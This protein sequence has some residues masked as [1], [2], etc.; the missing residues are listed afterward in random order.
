MPYTLLT[1]PDWVKKMP[2]GAQEIWVNAFNAAV[3]QYDDEETAFKIA[4]AAVKKKYKQNER[5]EW[6]L[7]ENIEEAEWDVKYINDLPDDCFAVILPGGEKD[8]EGKTVPR[9]LRYFPYKNAQGEID[10]PHLRN[11][12]ARLPQAKIPEE[13]RRKAE[14]VLKAAAKKMKVGEYAEEVEDKELFEALTVDTDT[15]RARVIL[16]KSGWSKNKR[17]YSPDVLG[18]AV[19]LFE[20]AKCYLDHEDVKGIS[21]R[22]V[23]E[24]AGFYE[25][26]A[27]INNRLE[28][29]LQFLDTEAGKIGLALAQESIKH[30]KPLAGLSLK[31]LGKLRKTEE[32]YIVEELQKVNSVD[33]VSEPAAGG[34]FIKL[35]ES[36]ME[37]DEMKDLTIE[38][39]KTERPDLIQEIT[40]EV[41]ERVYGKKTEVDKQLKEIKE[42]NE[43][44]AKEISE[45]RTY[46]QIKETETILEK[47]LSKSELPDIA[48]DRVRKLFEGKIAKVEDILESIK[49]EKE[50]IAKI[51]GEKPVNVGNGGK[52]TE[53]N[54]KVYEDKQ[55]KLLEAMGYSKS[56]IDKIM[57]VER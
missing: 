26:V 30:N 50:Y 10:L 32:G 18:E 48:K 7:K 20:G 19:S 52:N 22:S 3:K 1:I 2:K 43:K 37:D 29:D 41:E 25:N 6:V 46:G 33:I 15:N 14:Q 9:T 31:G 56:E 54:K 57:E 55:R 5:G 27:F 36:I 16:L 35:Y 39:L 17:F 28:G 47:E 4:I 24:L 49:A 38:K 51:A 45:W 8:E 40:D 11:A 23:R 34:E 44:L 42:Q 21:N 13:Y 12:L 53:D